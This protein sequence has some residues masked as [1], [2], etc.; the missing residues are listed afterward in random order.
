MTTR[1]LPPDT[2]RR[3]LAE[4]SDAA[5]GAVGMPFIDVRKSN[6][7]MQMAP[8]NS[9]VWVTYAY[10]GTAHAVRRDLFL[11]L[12]GYRDDLVHQGEEMD[13][14]VRLL[15]A[16]YFV[17]M[18]SAS[19]IRHCE[20]E[21]RDLA[22]M[23]RYGTRNAILFAWQNCP[24][25]ALPVQLVGTIVRLLL[26]TLNP[27]RFRI[28]AAAVVEGVREMSRRKR[29]P[30]QMTTYRLFRRLKKTGK[31]RLA[32]LRHRVGANEMRPAE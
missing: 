9:E 29:D 15:D 14:C 12:G 10:V 16:G 32:D 2:I 25:A 28:R 18:G 5:V 13:Y 11:A 7:V 8:D 23:D 24:L 4:F 3:T 6:R 26:W 31:L 21:R 20:S 27:P 22:R 30:V 17:R 19:P 1:R